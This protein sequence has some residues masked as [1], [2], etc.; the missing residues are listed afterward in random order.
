MPHPS[1][2]AE[3]TITPYDFP[4]PRP[5]QAPVLRPSG[6]VPAAD[7][8]PDGH[9]HRLRG[10]PP[11]PGGRPLRRPGAGG[12]RLRHHRHRPGALWRADLHPGA[13]GRP[14]Q[15]PDRHRRQHAQRLPGA[16]QD[17]RPR[18]QGHGGGELPGGRDPLG[19]HDRPLPPQQGGSA[20]R[21]LRGVPH[22]LCRAHRRAG[23]RLLRD[24]GAHAVEGAGAPLP[25]GVQPHLHGPGGD[26][27]AHPVHHRPGLRL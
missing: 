23:H 6:P 17:L 5:G 9:P 14:L 1:A 24:D 25:Q 18:R 3:R 2:G 8:H 7:R 10:G 15:G 16:G 20:G 26:P 21:H 11:V 19:H 27:G 22:P 4:S 12:G 13:A